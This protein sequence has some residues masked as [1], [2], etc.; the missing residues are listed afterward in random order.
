M[1]VPIPAVNP[2]VTGCGMNW[3][4]R[5]NPRA[6]MAT[7]MTPA[8]SVETMRPPTPNFAVMGDRG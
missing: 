6:P 5:P 2:V 4:S 8:I 1:T 3:M 7:S